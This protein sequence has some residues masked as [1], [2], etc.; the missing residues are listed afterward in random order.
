MV[1]PLLMYALKYYPIDKTCQSNFVK[2]VGRMRARSPQVDAA[3]G[4]T[5]RC[6]GAASWIDIPM[7]YLN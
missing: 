1:M 7:S 4:A 5:R 3:S 2:I 6:I